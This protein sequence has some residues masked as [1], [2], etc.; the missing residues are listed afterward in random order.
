LFQLSSRVDVI[1]LGF[2]VSEAAAGVFNAAYRVV[3]VLMFLT[4][5][6][7]LAVFP[8]ASRLYRDSRA[9][10]ARF[11]GELVRVAVLVAL[12][13][14]A[15]LAVVA[16]EVIRLLYGPGFEESILVLRLLA[17]VLAAV[18]V[19]IVLDVLLMSA[20]LERARTAIQARLAL[21][22]L[23]GNL[24]LIP[25]LG[26]IGAAVTTLV[27]E[28]VLVILLARRLGATVA[29]GP[30]GPSAIAA[31]LA[32]AA[33]A[34]PLALVPL[35][36]AAAVPAAALVYVAVISLFPGIRSGALALLREPAGEPRSPAPA[37]PAEGAS[38][39]ERHIL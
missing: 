20:D 34:V 14:A 7:S 31:G 9:E 1:C 2:I 22:N 28:T 17:G 5:L 19:K 38:G 25:W 29:V 26:V 12:P 36:L 10:H 13:A 32:S 15:G 11:A 35:P 27:T 6:A 33:F 39:A 8:I 3:H 37:G 24:A 4:H 23:G 21:V 30:I 18:I 16:P